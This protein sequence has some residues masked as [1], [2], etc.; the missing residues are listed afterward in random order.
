[1]DLRHAIGFLK[2]KKYQ[3]CDFLEKNGSNIATIL[4]D[5]EK[6]FDKIDHK[7]LFEA[8]YRIDV[9]SKLLCLMEN[10]YT[11]P[12]FKVSNNEGESDFHIHKAGIRQGCPLSPY[13]LVLVVSVI[14]QDIKS[15]LATPKQKEPIPGIL[16]ANLFYADGTLIFG[17]HTPSINKPLKAIEQ[18]SWYYSMKLNYEKCINLTTSRRTSSIK[19]KDGST[20]PRKKR[21]VYLGSLLTDTIDNA[22][23]V[24]N[25]IATDWKT[26]EDLLGQ[27]KHYHGLEIASFQW[28][29]PIQNSL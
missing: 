28:C 22:A 4:L 1:M 13:L 24:S 3:S 29:N 9:L 12:R 8:L 21:A 19:F 15:S 23:E 11:N 27:G 16:F 18:E 14:F 20:V 5:W 7:R 26:A 10:I 17:N 2:R 6:A 25:R